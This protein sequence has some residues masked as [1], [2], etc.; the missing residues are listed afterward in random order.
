MKINTK[1]FGEIEIEEC[2]IINFPKGLLGFE[3]LKE[4]IV[5]DI[6]NGNLSCL[7]SLGDSNIAF[8]IIRPWDY[9]E[10]YDINIDDDGLNALNIKEESQI[11]LYNIVTIPG[12]IKKMTANLLAPIVINIE[13]NSAKQIVLENSN[14]A[15]KHPLY[16]DSE[17]ATNAS[18]Y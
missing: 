6:P 12:D 14:Y 4:Y 5:L 18:S 8:I 7:Q 11:A 10:D 3:D 2:A 16:N 9:F 15:T 17:V 1:F 13:N